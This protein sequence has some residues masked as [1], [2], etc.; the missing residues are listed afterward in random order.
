MVSNIVTE[1]L[2]GMLT[3]GDLAARVGMN[4]A[5]LREWERRHGFPVPKRLPSGHRRFPQSA[6]DQ[7]RAVLERQRAGLSLPAAIRQAVSGEPS[8]ASIFA[9]VASA[10]G[11]PP[12][13][14]S[15]RAMVA[16]SR[17][18]EDAC[19]AAGGS[20][21]VVGSFQREAVYRACEPRWREMARGAA[22]CVALADFREVGGEGAVVEVPVMPSSPLHRE[23]A[24]AVSGPR[25]AVVLS[26]WEWPD[27]RQTG[28]EAVWS[29][30]PHV[31]AAAIE[32]AVALAR[33]AAPE[34]VGEVVVPTPT[35]DTLPAAM[36]L[37]DR[38]V[39]R[40]D[41]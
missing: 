1:N 9:A 18:I 13:Q 27:Q 10:A 28:F 21:V 23:W 3:I 39:S 33:V 29:I 15:R 8:D 34:R 22:L 26:G 19:V 11:R 40:L 7:V 38:L 24:L 30:E 6:V 36:A 4:T 5:T 2:H 31:V 12:V 37:V 41:R 16:F 17:A 32:T 20:T 35:G 25:L 14:R